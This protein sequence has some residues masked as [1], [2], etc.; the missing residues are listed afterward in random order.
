MSR[1]MQENAA[2]DFLGDRVNEPRANSRTIEQDTT[3]IPIRAINQKIYLLLDPLKNRL[4]ADRVSK[5][6]GERVIILP[7]RSVAEAANQLESLGL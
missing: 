5:M 6:A 1:I 7:Y 4:V 2:S 3:Q